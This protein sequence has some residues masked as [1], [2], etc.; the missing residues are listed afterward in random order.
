MI[1]LSDVKVAVLDNSSLLDIIARAL[2]V[3]PADVQDYKILRRSVD[4]RKKDA[5]CYVYTFAVSV[6]AEQKIINKKIKNVAPYVHKAYTFPY[7]N[8]S[9][10][11]R[12]IIV[13]T[14]PAG[15]FCA[16]FLAKAGL[17]PILNLKVK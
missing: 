16:L 8:I 5:I 17:K 3:S 10:D 13:G 2:S 7:K 11:K 15:L 14:G 6:K 12:P 9:A 1:K 4:A